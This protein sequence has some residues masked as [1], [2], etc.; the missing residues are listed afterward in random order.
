MIGLTAKV[1]HSCRPP[2]PNTQGSAGMTVPV[3]CSAPAAFQIPTVWFSRRPTPLSWNTARPVIVVGAVRSNDHP[4]VNRSV[5]QLQ[6]GGSTVKKLA[7]NSGSL[8]SRG[9]CG[10]E[11]AHKNNW[12][13]FPHGILLP[14]DRER[15]W[16]QY[17]SHLCALHGPSLDIESKKDGIRL[18]VGMRKSLHTPS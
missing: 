4:S 10:H 9:Q 13:N 2:W 1:H 16:G 17:Y 18:W 8:K 3:T 14:P 11:A 15:I 12:Q 6:A 7:E 5:A